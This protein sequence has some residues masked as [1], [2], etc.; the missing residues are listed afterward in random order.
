MNRRSFVKLAGTG[1][2]ALC[3]MPLLA[4]STKAR[5]SAF[6][7]P[8][9]PYAEDAL[10]PVISARTVSYHYGKHTKAYYS[11]LPSDYEGYAGKPLEHMIITSRQMKQ[12]GVFNN[13]AQAWNH[14]FYWNGLMPG[15]GGHPT[16]DLARAIEAD[17][18]SFESFRDSFLSTAGS[19]FGSGWC[20]LVRR[21][22]HLEVMGTSNANTPVAME[23]VEPLWT[24]DVWEHAYYLD[25]QNRRGDYLRGVFDKLA[26]WEF[27]AGNLR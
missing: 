26:N 27:V 4:M 10:E 20:W 9:L 5:A 6:S 16:G 7:V 19:V 23:G 18:G 8:P 21:N 13:S 11:K 12:Q 2:A 25:W 22:G 1:A 15:G 24:V 17:F 3:A 14:T